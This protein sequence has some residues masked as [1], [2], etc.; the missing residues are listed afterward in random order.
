[1]SKVTSKLQVTL[2]K[3]VAEHF[4]IKPGDEIH[5]EIAG[6]AMRVVP[7]T[8]KRSAKQDDSSFCLRLF[9]QA[10]RRQRQR[11]TSF[12]SEMMRTRGQG[13][14]W[15]RENLYTRGGAHRH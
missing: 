2:P 10:T 4:G 3:V 8:K 15:K 12:D 6:D 13:R 11:E 1:M 9:D 5:W 14:G 7:K